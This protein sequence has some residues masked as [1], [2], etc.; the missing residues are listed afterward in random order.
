MERE[1]GGKIRRKPVNRDT[2][3][4]D[5]EKAY[6]ALARKKNLI[7]H[8]IPTGKHVSPMGTNIQKVNSMHR[9]LGKWMGQFNGVATKY[10]QNYMNYFITIEKS[11]GYRNRL[12]KIWEWIIS[13]KQVFMNYRYIYQQ[14]HR[15]IVR[16]IFCIKKGKSH[17]FVFAQLNKAFTHECKNTHSS[18]IG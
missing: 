12:V 4:T 13:N 16:A 1:L 8:K 18:N 3:V 2:L 6:N 14:F 15:T 5:S 17:S 11:K 10:L 9:R 7:H